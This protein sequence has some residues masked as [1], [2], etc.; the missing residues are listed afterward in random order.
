MLTFFQPLYCGPGA[1]DSSGRRQQTRRVTR[2]RRGVPKCACTWKDPSKKNKSGTVK[3]KDKSKGK[4]VLF[5]LTSV[6][7]LLTVFINQPA[8]RVQSVK[9]AKV[10]LLSCGCPSDGVNGAGSTLKLEKTPKQLLI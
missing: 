10:R 8:E 1:M 5:E 7:N 3:G 9:R 6:F 2:L 4:K